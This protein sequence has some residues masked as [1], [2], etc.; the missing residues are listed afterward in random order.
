MPLA[1][2]GPR[3]WPRL[4]NP[5]WFALAAI[6]FSTTIEVLQFVINVVLGYPHSTDIDDVIVNA[7]GSVIAFAVLRLVLRLSG[8]T[9]TSSR[10]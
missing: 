4:R 1:W 9:Q 2:Y 3:L 5:V 10:G 6:L 8:R 7:T